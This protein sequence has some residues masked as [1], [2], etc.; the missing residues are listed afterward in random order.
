MVEVSAART[1]LIVDGDDT[2][3][4]LLHT[5]LTGQG[6]AITSCTSM[7]D[8]Q[9]TVDDSTFDLMI[10]SDALPDGRGLHLVR[11]CATTAP[12]MGIIV[13]SDRDRTES[14][15]RAL[16]SGADDYLTRPLRPALAVARV[17]SVLDTA[18]DRHRSGAPALLD[19]P[20]ID[21]HLEQAQGGRAKLQAICDILRDGLDA[22]RAS[23]FGLKADTFELV[24][25]V[26]HGDDGL[27]TPLIHMPADA[28][29]AGATV[30]SGDL[31]N[32]P[33]AY[34]D[35]RFNRSFDEQTGFVT[36]S[37]LSVPL[38]DQHGQLVGVAQVLNHSTG[39]FSA[40]CEVIARQLATRC[41]AALLEAFYADRLDGE[42]HLAATIARAPADV[43]INTTQ[44]LAGT[45]ALTQVLPDLPERFDPAQ[46][47]GSIIG[48]YEVKAVLGRG[49]Q[50]LVLEGE[51]AFLERAV[52]IKLLGPDSASVQSLRRQF[53][54][55]MRSMALLSHPN[56]VSVYDAG[57]HEGALF[58]VMEKCSRGTALGRLRASGAMPLLEATQVVR[59]ACRGLDA[60]HR[61]G[62]VHCDIKPDNILLDDHEAKL[63]D[64]GLVL[65]ANTEGDGSGR[66]AGTPHYMSPEQCD[67]KAVDHRSDIY[68]LGA[69]FFH[70]ATG[71]APFADAKDVGRVMDRHRREPVRDP[72]LLDPALPPDLSVI[73]ATAMAKDPLDRYQ[74]AQAML[75]DLDALLAVT[76]LRG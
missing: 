21:R 20:G 15:I 64:F 46:M 32:V 62:M 34:D 71:E 14:V 6:M 30:Q 54:R 60:A 42:V 27:D 5:N 11:H 69:T 9:R 10:V 37:V 47:I 48:R 26:A 23:V 41:A 22:E 59:D 73:V 18:A 66:V 25:V 63:S 52:A 65:A 53:M 50:G 7:A 8:A 33:D 13:V 39:T 57:E 24:T 49:S 75:D 36:R 35:A 74:S 51:D 45:D 4:E 55:E 40:A 28:G 61:R 2:S 68:A 56:T 38:R 72:R 1:V 29:L 31:V 70:L 17:R 58:L 44:V 67:G 76:R 3:R 43:G 12:G 16:E 19:L